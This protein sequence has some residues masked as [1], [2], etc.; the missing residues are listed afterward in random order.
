[1]K[2]P[3]SLAPVLCQSI[4]LPDEA[5]APEWIHLLPA[6][7]VQTVD[8]RGPYKVGDLDKIIQNSTAVAPR[9]V[10]DVNHATD[11][12]APRG[13]DAPARGWIV[14]LQARKNGTSEDGIWGRVEWTPTGSAL[15]AEKSY[16]HISPVIQRDKNNN[17]T[18]VLRASLVNRPNLIGLTALNAPQE[19]NMDLIAQIRQ[20]LG[21]PDDADDTAILAALKG[22]NAMAL[23]STTIA[24]ELGVDAESTVVLNAV[25]ERTDPKKMVPVSAVIELQ[26]EVKDLRASV[27]KDRATAFIDGAIKRGVVGVKPLRDH[28]IERH[29]ADPAAVEKEIAA[30]PVSDLTKPSGATNE[31]PPADK[32]KDGLTAEER[33]AIE[34]MCIDPE[35]FKAQKVKQ[36]AKEEML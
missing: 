26:Q 17:V 30:L 24:K 20:L 8:G 15:V 10:L 4:A 34:L 25:R 22:S 32:G 6:G 14:E 7:T 2:I 27:G 16:R 36:E 31:P 21:L 23:C 11:L 33:K 12:A 28:Y 29:L 19:M 5:G 3:G 1:M 9:Q 35:A 18:H 13:E